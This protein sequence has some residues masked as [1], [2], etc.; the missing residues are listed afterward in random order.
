M[1]SLIYLG[2]VNNVI[3]IDFI[4]GIIYYYIVRVCNEMGCV[5][6]N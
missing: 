3:D 6:S 1:G 4:N 5:D 2:E